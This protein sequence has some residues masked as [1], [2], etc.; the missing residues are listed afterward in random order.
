[1]ADAQNQPSETSPLLRNSNKNPASY[2]ESGESVVGPL[3]NGAADQNNGI[4]GDPERQA[5]NSD[6]NQLKGLPEVRKQLKY[7]LPA[8]SIGVWLVAADQTLVASAYGKMGSEL[9]SLN[10][11]SWIAS[12]YFLTLTSFQPLYGKLSDIFGRK[13]CLLFSY[14]I[15]GLGCLFCGLA[16]TMNQLIVARAVAGIGGG[17]ITTVGSIMMSD[18]VP[19]RERGTWQ[20]VINIVYAFGSGTGAPL[21]GFLSDTIGWRVA[22]IAQFPLC[23]IAFLAVLFALKLPASDKEH[24][25]AK[26][27]KVDFPG[28]FTLV[29]AVASLL[30][31]LD[32]GSNVSWKSSITIAF[33]SLTVPATALFLWI[34]L[35]YATNPFAPSRI[36]FERSLAAA[37]WC[38]FFAFAGWFGVLFYIPLFYQT[39]FESSAT[40]AG[41]QL[42]PAILLSVTG[43]LTGGF[44]IQKTGRVR[45]IFFALQL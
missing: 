9:N 31:G 38:N 35:K 40:D 20:G 39:S 13:A 36:I 11:T 24:W 21:G 32:Q 22:F 30:V 1:M 37:Y 8:M 23:I 17:G 7:I 25:Q 45:L 43:S 33:L 27:K 26:L 15:F 44:I 16:Q 34:E 5:V 3:P 29:I 12:A 4:N 10:N 28:A 14:T 19:L 18:I 42:L 2:V 6:A 41:L